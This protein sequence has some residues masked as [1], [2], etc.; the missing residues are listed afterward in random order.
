MIKKDV[1]E[2]EFENL[3]KPI[4]TDDGVDLSL[5]SGLDLQMFIL[6]N[7][8]RNE[9]SERYPNPEVL[10]EEP[11]DTVDIRK[12][13]HDSKAP[14]FLRALTATKEAFDRVDI[15]QHLATESEKKAVRLYSH[16]T[17]YW[18]SL[19]P[20]V[21]KA[22]LDLDLYEIVESYFKI[23]RKYGLTTNEEP[24]YFL[25]PQRKRKVK[26][27]GE[28]VKRTTQIDDSEIHISLLE[29]LV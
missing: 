16:I 24:Y 15:L 19:E 7:K 28:I 11:T 13:K 8:I 6:Y 2:K 4:L 12:A 5:M 1:A 29:G 10:R 27:E 3:L 21:H 9:L 23:M 17:Y 26:V 18:D 25:S 14:L 22:I 20:K